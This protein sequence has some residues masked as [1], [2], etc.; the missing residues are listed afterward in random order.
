M[1]I[2]ICIYIYIY[3]SVMQIQFSFKNVKSKVARVTQAR[4]FLT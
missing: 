2:Y 1:N 3:M 4:H